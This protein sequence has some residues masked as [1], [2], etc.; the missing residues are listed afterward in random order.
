ME[1]YKREREREEPMS[2]QTWNTRKYLL[3]SGKESGVKDSAALA[4]ALA[5]TEERKCGG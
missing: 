5:A 1:K 3:K 2:V 4:L